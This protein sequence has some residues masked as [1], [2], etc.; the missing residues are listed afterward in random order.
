M[1][2]MRMSAYVK[3]AAQRSCCGHES[4]VASSS[5]SL[6]SSLAPPALPDFAVPSSSFF[7][8]AE[9]ED[10]APPEAEFGIGVVDLAKGASSSRAV[11]STVCA[12]A[13]DAR[14]PFLQLRCQPPSRM[15]GAAA[16]RRVR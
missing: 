16:L 4:Q 14:S 6:S 7:E 12:S 3:L 13:G 8:A 11:A 15:S 5:A 2:H 10:V 9:L 1:G